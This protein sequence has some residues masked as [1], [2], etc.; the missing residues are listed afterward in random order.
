MVGVS[1]EVAA[2]RYDVT[3]TAARAASTD[4]R[5]PTCSSPLTVGAVAVASGKLKL[6]GMLDTIGVRLGQAAAGELGHVEL[7]EMLCQDETA[8]RDDAGLTRRVKAARFEQ[9]ATIEDYDFSFNP[10]IPVAQ[11]RDLA[12]RNHIELT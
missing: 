6:F 7:L 11:I 3:P 4:S 9:L 10:K 12:L 1:A 8:R 2:L 5:T